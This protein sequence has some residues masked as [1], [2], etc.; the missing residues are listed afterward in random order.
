MQESQV[1]AP[2]LSFALLTPKAHNVELGIHIR[3]CLS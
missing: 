1:L 2:F 3:K